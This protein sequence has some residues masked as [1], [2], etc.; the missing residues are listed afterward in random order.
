MKTFLRV[1]TAAAALLCVA[2]AAYADAPSVGLAAVPPASPPAIGAPLNLE[3]LAAISGGE[4]VKV[5]VLSDQTLTATNRGNTINADVV[6]SGA[7][8]FGAGAFDGF[9]GVGNFVINTGNNNNLQGSLSVNV[10]AL[11]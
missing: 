5:S 6:Q 7:V 8:S 9:N 11:P 4:S 2:P 3:E 1:T 10:V